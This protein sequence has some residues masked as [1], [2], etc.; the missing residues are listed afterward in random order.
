VFLRRKLS[1]VALRGLFALEFH[2][3]NGMARELSFAL[4][5]TA[6][7]WGTVVVHLVVEDGIGLW[8]G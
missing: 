2:G 3:L 5:H 6:L 8:L 1:Q 4:V 7:F